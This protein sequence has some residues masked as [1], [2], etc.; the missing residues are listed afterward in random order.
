MLSCHL[1]G[2]SE[3]AENDDSWST[4]GRGQFDQAS[5]I[6]EVR[7][8]VFCCQIFLHTSILIILVAVFVL[9]PGEKKG[10]K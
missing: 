8:S 7:Y 6:S 1:Q 10:I 9:F 3:D 4:E 5:E 2:D